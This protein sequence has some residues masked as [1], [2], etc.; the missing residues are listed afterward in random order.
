MDR[1][2]WEQVTNANRFL[3]MVV[4]SILSEKSVALVLPVGVPWREKLLDMIEAK[5]AKKNSKNSFDFIDSPGGQVGEFLL[6]KYCKEE[7]RAQYRPNKSY[8]RFLAESGDIVLNDKF[9]W[10]RDIS[11]KEYDE[12]VNFVSDYCIHVRKDLSPAVFILET[13]DEAMAHR[14]KKGISKI[15]YSNEINLFD[16][17]TFCTLAVSSVQCKTYMK[18]YLAELVSNICGDDIELCSQCIQRGKTFLEDPI[19][20]LANI[21]S[22]CTRSNGLGFNYIMNEKIINKKVWKT[23]LKTIFPIIEDYRSDFVVKYDE[24][25][26]QQLP[27]KSSNGEEF[28]EPTEVEIGTLNYMISTGLISGVREYN[29]L[30]LFK[31]AR[32]TLAHLKILRIEDVDK[33]LAE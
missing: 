2:W 10:V 28:T 5:V 15:I 18:V 22:Q 14:A 12:W 3:E 6:G 25:I 9:V 1:V 20:V 21:K 7:K 33:I 31:E 29:R 16:S 17:Y 19:K 30:Y 32:N 8:A 13:N 23:Q 4:S 26:R 11:L 27:I 24:K